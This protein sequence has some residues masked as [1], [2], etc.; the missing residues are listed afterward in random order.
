M[1]SAF[2][3]VLGRVGEELPCTL[4]VSTPVGRRVVCQTYHPRCRVQIEEYILFADLIVLPMHDFDVILGMD[5]L[6]RY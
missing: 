6:A 1:S 2:A 3:V 4:V 5:W